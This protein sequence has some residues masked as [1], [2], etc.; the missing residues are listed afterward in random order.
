MRPVEAAGT[1]HPAAVDMSLPEAEADKT[2]PA[3]DSED[4]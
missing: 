1:N 3:V 4:N 2:R